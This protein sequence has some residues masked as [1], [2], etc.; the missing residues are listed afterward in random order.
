MTFEFRK[1]KM[2]LHH[3]GGKDT[4]TYTLKGEDKAGNTLTLEV[5]GKDDASSEGTV[6][7][8]GDKLTLKMGDEVTV[9]NRISKREF[10]KRHEQGKTR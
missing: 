3:P 1:G 2:I 9:L 7:L 6:G 10:K 8:E 4:T 5:A